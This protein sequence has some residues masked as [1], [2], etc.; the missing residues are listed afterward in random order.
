MGEKAS[1]FVPIPIASVRF[2]Y[3]LKEGTS[4]KEWIREDGLREELKKKNYSGK[5][6]L[7]AIVSDQTG[8]KFK[9]D[10]PI[11]FDVDK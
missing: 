9:S 7:V 11:E 1:L 8:K 4:C 2:P 3:E 6:K 10:E 5:V